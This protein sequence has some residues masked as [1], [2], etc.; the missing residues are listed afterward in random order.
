MPDLARCLI[1]PRRRLY[2]HRHS[3]PLS[4]AA[5]HFR[6]RRCAS[7]LTRGRFA[8]LLAGVD[9]CHDASKFDYSPRRL[10]LCLSLFYLRRAESPGHFSS[11]AP[12]A[13]G[14]RAVRFSIIDA[15]LNDNRRDF[16]RLPQLAKSTAW[17]V[18]GG[19]RQECKARH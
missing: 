16:E 13:A 6:R 9:A 5:H 15:S 10:R 3:M 8:R 18:I 7:R 11:S 17:R 4:L 1:W 12:R 19:A 2:G 14:H